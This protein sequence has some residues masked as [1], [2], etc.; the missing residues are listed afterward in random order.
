MFYPTSEDIT[1]MEVR[2]K[3]EREFIFKKKYGYQQSY[4]L[5]KKLIMKNRMNI[6]LN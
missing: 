6:S 3:E 5:K 4:N 2:K 1:A